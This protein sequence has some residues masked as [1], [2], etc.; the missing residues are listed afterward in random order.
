MRREGWA[1]LQN[2]WVM[3]LSMEESGQQFFKTRLGSPVYVHLFG[4]ILV[5]LDN[6]VAVMIKVAMTVWFLYCDKLTWST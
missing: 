3:L 2:A 5:Q 1:G 4:N 6:A